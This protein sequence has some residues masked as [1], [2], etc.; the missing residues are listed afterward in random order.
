ML[1]SRDALLPPTPTMDLHPSPDACTGAP[2]LSP[3]LSQVRF[4]FSAGSAGPA[5]EVEGPALSPPVPQGRT[6]SIILGRA[7][8]YPGA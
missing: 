7:G 3:S 5:R 2:V 1:Q 6:S 8:G 4:T